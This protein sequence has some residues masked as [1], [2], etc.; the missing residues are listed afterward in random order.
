M[1][2]VTVYIPIEWI[3]RELNSTLLLTK[4][5]IK[6]KLRVI[7]GSKRSIFFYLKHKKSKSGIFFY[8]GGL[9]KNICEF[10]NEKCNKLVILDQE[11]GPI[12]NDDSLIYKIKTRFFKNT[13]KFISRYYC[14][15][16]KVFKTSK[17]ILEPHINGKVVLS[18]WPRVDLW[19]KKYPKIFL[20]ENNFIKKKYNNYILFSS[21]FICLN[22]NEIKN[23]KKRVKTYWTS[24]KHPVKKK[25][26]QM[27]NS[28]KEFKNFKL[29]LKEYSNIKT[30]PTLIIRPHPN[31]DIDVWKKI[32]KNYDN[33]FV[34]SKFDIHPWIYNSE[35]ILH[36]G[37]TSSVHA[38]VAKKK[39]VM[40]KLYKKFT[41]PQYIK[42]SNFIIQ[43]AKQL[44][45]LLK[46][47]YT[48]SNL[49]VSNDIVFKSKIL[50]SKRISDDLK[51][52]ENL[53]KEKIHY[54][55][56]KVKIIYNLKT[57]YYRY[58]NIFKFSLTKKNKF[59]GGINEKNIRE[60][61]KNINVKKSNI[62]TLL[63]NLIALE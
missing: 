22:L 24:H 21:N 15:N 49:G 62:V 30:L 19:R 29:F 31:E 45:K 46:E 34:E 44:N 59:D 7:I 16:K 51:N 3:N 37:C 1:L 25:V 40:L 52:I 8:K 61:L 27:L 35:L 17:K 60:K 2:K 54:F 5:L 13:L 6:K 32:T 33:I 41:L 36:R 55:D 43:N 4:F 63:P 26:Q 42:V 39:V 11:I 48:K 28:Y 57:L 50:S 23:F 14:I 20:T 58:K 56:Y 38:Q 9:E 53:N 18:G 10:I 12:N 47:K